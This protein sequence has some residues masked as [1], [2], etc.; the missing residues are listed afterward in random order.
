[1][2][3]GRIEDIIGVCAR[4]STKYN[5]VPKKIVIYNDEEDIQT[6]EKYKNQDSDNSNNSDNLF[7]AFEP[8]WS[9]NDIYLNEGSKNNILTALA[10][11]KYREKLF[12]EWNIKGNKNDGRA[13]CLNFW[14]N[15]GTGKSMTAEGVANYLNKKILIVNYPELESKYVGETP[16]NIKKVFE[17]AKKE[18]AVIVL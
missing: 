16:K 4:T 13:L 7:N 10:M 3:S 2:V 9:L 12:N 14:G 17:K 6:S 15:P 5:E 11:I 1:M 18:D 8:K